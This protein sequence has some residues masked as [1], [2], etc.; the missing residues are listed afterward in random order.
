[1]RVKIIKLIKLK[2]KEKPIINIKVNKVN[3]INLLFNNLLINKIDNIN[4][5]IKKELQLFLIIRFF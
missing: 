5:F 1:L 2:V 4:I 3:K